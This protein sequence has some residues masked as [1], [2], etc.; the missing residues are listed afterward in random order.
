MNLVEVLVAASVFAISS[1]ASF[2]LWVAGSSWS[3][4]ADQQGR[5]QGELE[6]QLLAVQG[7]LQRLAG[8]PL[9]ADC[10]VAADWLVSHLPVLERQGVG[11]RLQLQHTD[12][13]QRQ[14]WYDP[15]AYGLC[16]GAPQEASDGML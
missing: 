6:A 8:E 15:A 3:Q 7:Q 12:G 2:Q 14:R 16:S 11:V 10:A 13:S 1:T 4:R 5:Q 9:A